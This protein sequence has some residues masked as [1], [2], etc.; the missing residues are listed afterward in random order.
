[1]PNDH[2]FYKTKKQYRLKPYSLS[3]TAMQKGLYL[4]RILTSITPGPVVGGG[5]RDFHFCLP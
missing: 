4:S 5:G 3:L 1:M 2:M